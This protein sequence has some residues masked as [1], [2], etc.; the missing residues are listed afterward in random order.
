VR[1]Y[2]Q[3][4]MEEKSVEFRKTKEIYVKI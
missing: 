2:A 1:E 3:Q 4:G